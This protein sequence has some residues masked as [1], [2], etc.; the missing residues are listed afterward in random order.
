MDIG[1]LEGNQAFLDR[2]KE[3][4]PHRCRTKVK[5]P[6]PEH[7]QAKIP[8][9]DFIRAPLVKEAEWGFRTGFDMLRF[10]TEYVTKDNAE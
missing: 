9:L 4:H 5:W 3:S 2:H 10:K 8:D 1:R 6:K 7:V